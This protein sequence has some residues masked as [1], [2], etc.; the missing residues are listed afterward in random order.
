MDFRLLMIGLMA[1]T[2]G[3][4]LVIFRRS[5]A[6]QSE[7]QSSKL[8]MWLEGPYRKYNAALHWFIVI[9][10]IAIGVA[11]IALAPF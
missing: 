3:A 1:T 5:L 9:F 2:A 11:C 10:L 4:L 6:A 8:P 7:R